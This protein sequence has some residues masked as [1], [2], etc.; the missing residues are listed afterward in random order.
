MELVPSLPTRA[1]VKR[2]I[3]AFPSVGGMVP[4]IATS[5]DFGD[6]CLPSDLRALLGRQAGQQAPAVRRFERLRH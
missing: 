1:A 2:A 4:E 3:A 5:L 6:P